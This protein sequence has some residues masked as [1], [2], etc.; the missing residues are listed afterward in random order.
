MGAVVASSSPPS[1]PP[2]GTVALL[3]FMTYVPAL[4][5]LALVVLAM[6]L[7]CGA[8]GFR[9]VLVGTCI[10]LLG[11]QVGSRGSVWSAVCGGQG[12]GVGRRLDNRRES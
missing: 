2:D 9:I 3:E 6:Y 7:R 1:P 10:C 11:F 8:F 4:G 5:T 12:G